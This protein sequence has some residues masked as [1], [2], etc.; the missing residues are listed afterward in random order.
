MLITIIALLAK[1][2]DK[3]ILYFFGNKFY[4]AILCYNMTRD[5]NIRIVLWEVDTT[6]CHEKCG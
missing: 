2:F 3:L 6:Q 4:S 1:D 5:M